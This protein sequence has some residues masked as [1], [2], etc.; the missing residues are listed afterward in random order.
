[1]TDNWGFTDIEAAI[2]TISDWMNY[3]NW[4]GPGVD[5]NRWI[6]SGRK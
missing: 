2:N 3:V 5:V 1:M 4:L 6:V